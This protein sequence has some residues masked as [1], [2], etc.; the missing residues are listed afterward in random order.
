MT[1]SP[2]L[3]DAQ[4]STPK[5]ANR[6][7][8][9][10]LGALPVAALAVAACSK[11]QAEKTATEAKELGPPPRPATPDEA[12]T[13]LME[14]NKRF[15]D[16]RPEV[17]D[18]AEI[19]TVWTSIST[20]QQPFATILTCADSRLGPELIF[21]QFVGDIF[22]VREAGNIADSPTNL[23]SIEFGQ[24]VLGSKVLMVLGHS[25]CGAVKAALEKATPGANIQAIIDAIAPGIAGATDLDD[26]IIRNVRAVI[27][28][29]RTKSTLLRD[30]EKAGAVKIVGAVYNIKTAEVTL[31]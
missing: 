31:L 19:K 20:G 21:D 7:R 3:P 26:A 23:G 14:G 30:A 1:S 13:V 12:I 15:V 18:T 2:D 28:R 22:V 17:R 24:A 9:Y 6:S 4:N 11:D 8:R 5:P 27:D 25:D 16:R 29:I 10:L